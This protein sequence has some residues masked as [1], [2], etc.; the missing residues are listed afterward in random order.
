M[1]NSEELRQ[2][3]ATPKKRRELVEWL[4][5]PPS[6]DHW[7]EDGWRQRCRDDFSTTACAL[8]ALA[9]DGEWPRTRW[10]E[11]LQAWAEES[12]LRRSWRCMSSL[13]DSAPDHVLKDI[14]RPLGWWLQSLAKTFE[15]HEPVFFNLI[16]RVLEVEKN[17]VISAEDDP[18]SRAINHPIGHV[19][20]AAL[21]W[22]YRQ[23]KPLEDGQG[24]PDIIKHLFADLCNM[25]VASF[26]HGRVVLATHVITLFRVDPPWATKY[27][28][29]V[30]DWQQSRDEARAAWEGFLWSP[31]I[32]WP[33][34]AAFKQPFL[35]TA[36]HYSQLGRHKDQYAALLT[37][38]ALESG[39]TLSKSELANAT[40][41]LPSE[42]LYGATQALVRA[43]E[44]AGEQRS[45]YWSHRVLPYVQNIWPKSRDVASPGIS[46][47]LA[48]LCVAAGDAFPEAL[49]EIKYWLQPLELPDDVV[50][51]LHE[52]QLPG[53]FPEPA[54]A[55][56]DAVIGD[57][58]QWPPS[59]L[60]DCLDAIRHAQPNLEADGRFQRL[61]EYLRRHDGS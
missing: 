34:I 44:G 1:G 42:G 51:L 61:V 28:L 11:A 49:S 6:L 21:R 39:E 3:V 43:L 50:R 7:Q 22:W 14:T 48:E 27:L 32:Y 47:S 5:H 13:L 15:G 23:Q 45:E 36:R 2:S 16:R 41:S 55:F 57:N 8:A 38:A 40:R 18:V 46:E 19:T 59:H 20:E 58:A 37:F 30:F 9:R 54:L 60:K 29:P 56:L 26:R 10:R 53:Q 24:L 4:K 33:L 52:A 12:L 25:H 31:R 17:A 35:A